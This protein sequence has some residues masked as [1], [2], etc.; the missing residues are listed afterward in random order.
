AGPLQCGFAARN[1]DFQVSGPRRRARRNGN[2]KLSGLGRLVAGIV[3]RADAVTIG[4]IS[5]HGAIRRA[6]RRNPCPEVSISVNVVTIQTRGLLVRVAW[7]SRG[8]PRKAHFIATESV[9]E[10]ACR[11]ARWS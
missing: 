7:I 8:R 4:G 9:Q 1:G 3:H 2:T 11:N 5:A 6:W 10:E